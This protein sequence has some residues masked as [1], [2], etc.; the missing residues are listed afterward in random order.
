MLTGVIDHIVHRTERRSI[1]SRG[2]VVAMDVTRTVN[3]AVV[4]GGPAGLTA[5]RR[6]RRDGFDAVVVE[7]RDRVRWSQFEPPD[8]RRQDRRGSIGNG[9][10]RSGPG[11]GAVEQVAGGDLSHLPPRRHLFEHRGNLRGYGFRRSPRPSC[12]MP[13]S[14]CRGWIGCRAVPADRP[15]SAVRARQWDT[16]TVGS[17]TGERSDTEITAS[18]GGIRPA[19][20]A[21]ADSARSLQ[22]SAHPR[23]N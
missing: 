19:I 7:A 21:S 22:P 20:A 12:W 4:G 10:A 5:A 11:A 1:R 8:R 16:E 17:C 9:R 14:V 15:W 3:I 2:S 6:L 18:V 23:T 13:I